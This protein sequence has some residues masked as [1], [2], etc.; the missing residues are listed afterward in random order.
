MIDRMEAEMTPAGKAE[1]S[2]RALHLV[3]LLMFVQKY[4]RDIKYCVTAAQADAIWTRL[5]ATT[6][7]FSRNMLAAMTDVL[8]LLF[9]YVKYSEE[10]KGGVV[11]DQ[12]AL[13][14]EKMVKMD[15]EDQLGLITTYLV[16]RHGAETVKTMLTACE[17]TL[18]KINGGAVRAQTIAIA[19][20]CLTEQ[21]QRLA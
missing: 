18:D 14:Y 12:L 11:A 16:G 6:D 1:P 17:E 13:V 10:Y 4:T 21:I 3:R 2:K 19:K 9:L 5:Q 20:K 7:D 8:D 15:Q